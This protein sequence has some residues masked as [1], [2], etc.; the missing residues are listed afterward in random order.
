M[1]I[2]MHHDYHYFNCIIDR[3]GKVYWLK[4][5]MDCR[6]IED[7]IDGISRDIDPTDTVSIMENLEKLSYRTKKSFE[8]LENLDDRYRF[9]VKII[10]KDTKKITRNREDWEF[11][12]W[13]MGISPIWFRENREQYEEN[14]WKCWE[15]SVKINLVIDYETINIKD[16]FIFAT[17]NSKVEAHGNAKV[18]ILNNAIVEAY[19]NA[20][21]IAYDNT[22]VY[23]YD[24]VIVDANYGHTKVE[25]HGNS[26][27]NV[28]SHEDV[29]ASDNSTV[30]A[31]IH[32]IV[33]AD[34]NARVDAYGNAS[35]ESHDN[36]T[37]KA[38]NHATVDAWG[39]MIEAYDC[40][41]VWRCWHDAKIAIKSK[42]AVV[43]DTDLVKGDDNQFHITGKI[44]VSKDAIVE[45]Q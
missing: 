27:V 21:V 10:P 16:I 40:A 15:E 39:G 37:V 5:A 18:V 12:F 33:R 35:V 11:D 14:C 36:S 43:I 25:A 45:T 1:C 9:E 42:F 44:I 17:G 23:A 4:D 13:E 30:K 6:D 41:T 34:D 8:E 7:S 20:R 28:S 3:M 22:E 38:Y 2:A 29:T 26:I 32:A 24:N 31:S 19:D